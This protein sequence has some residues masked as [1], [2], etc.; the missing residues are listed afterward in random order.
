MLNKFIEYCA[1][2]EA[3]QILKIKFANQIINRGLAMVRLD[4]GPN[5]P[6][7]AAIVAAAHIS[8]DGEQ[9][10]GFSKCHSAFPM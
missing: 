9:F 8:L 6:G 7:T 5:Q 3:E 2:L 1:R 10:A 4:F